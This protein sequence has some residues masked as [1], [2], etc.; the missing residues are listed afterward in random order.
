MIGTPAAI[1]AWP[2]FA[3]ADLSQS[4][5]SGFWSA[6]LVFVGIAVMVFGTFAVVQ[7]QRWPGRTKTRKPREKKAAT[8]TFTPSAA[9]TSA[10]TPAGPTEATL[11]PTNQG[12][13]R[14]HFPQIDEAHPDVW[15][16]DRPLEVQVELGQHANGD[17]KVTLERHRGE[18]VHAVGERVPD[19]DRAVRFEIRFPHLGEEDL[20]VQVRHDE[21]VLAQ[22]VRAVRIVDYRAEIVETFEDFLA[23]AASQFDFVDTRRTAR[24]FVDRF[25]DGRPGVPHAPLETIAD[26]Y[27]VANYSEHDVDR[28]TYLA[29]VDAFLV[30]EEAGALESP[31]EAH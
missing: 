13:L 30:L 16:T 31:E 26:I 27:E 24:E 11:R 18:T 9:P 19:D 1:A 20:V 3:L 2:G 23:W 25:V 14:L 21:R 10:P 5:F 7:T 8:P 6:F 17:V 12:D 28:D 4:V 29:L 15:S 22:A